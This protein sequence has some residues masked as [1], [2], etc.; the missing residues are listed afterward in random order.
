MITDPAGVLSNIFR[1]IFDLDELSDAFTVRRINESKWDSLANAT[2]V[3][4]L[5][6]EFNITLDAQEIERLTSYQS[7]LLLVQE[8]VT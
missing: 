1:L 3:A 6:S 7:T 4:A 2:L 8:K 5:E